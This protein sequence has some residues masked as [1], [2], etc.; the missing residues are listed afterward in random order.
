LRGKWVQDRG[1]NVV[2]DGGR[3]RPEKHATFLRFILLETLGAQAAR[4]AS[5]TCI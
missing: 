4:Q 3:F 5:L 1:E 2:G